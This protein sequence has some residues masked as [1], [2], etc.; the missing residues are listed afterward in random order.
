MDDDGRM[1]LLAR[2]Y[3]LALGVTLGAVLW[4]ASVRDELA[5]AAAWIS[6]IEAQ[7]ALGDPGLVA[8]GR[9][10]NLASVERLPLP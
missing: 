6:R 2:G 4:S 3:G 1:N 5:T 10:A 7:Q 9:G 8:V